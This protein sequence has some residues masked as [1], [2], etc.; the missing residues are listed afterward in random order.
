MRYVIEG[1]V[2]DSST[3]T[4]VAGVR[5]EAWDKDLGVDDHLGSAETI[6]DGS[7]SIT[8]DEG[9]FRDLFWE[10]DEG[11]W[12]DLFWDRRPDIYFKP[13]LRVLGC[14]KPVCLRGPPPLLLKVRLRYFRRKQRGLGVQ[15]STH[16][17]LELAHQPLGDHAP[18]K[19]ITRSK[20]VDRELH[21]R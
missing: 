17:L 7:F 11:S 13:A 3:S 6:S 8:F 5:V 18:P 2:V 14:R 10:F 20:M 12:W 4:G 21:D 16:Y 19:S 15:L 1:R 9:M